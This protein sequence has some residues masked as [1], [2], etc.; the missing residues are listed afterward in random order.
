MRQLKRPWS[1]LTP[2]GASEHPDESINAQFA[3][4]TT[5]P[6]NPNTKKQELYVIGPTY[7]T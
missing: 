7:H 3:P 4:A 2:A 6:P 5:S 1:E